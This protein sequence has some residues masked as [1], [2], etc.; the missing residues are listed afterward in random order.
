MVSSFSAEAIMIPVPT[1]RGDA[2]CATTS[3]CYATPENLD[4]PVPSQGYDRTFKTMESIQRE[5]TK[6]TMSIAVD[7]LT[8]FKRGSVPRR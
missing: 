8:N 3:G 5:E 7:A 4:Q 2:G 6:T 1:G